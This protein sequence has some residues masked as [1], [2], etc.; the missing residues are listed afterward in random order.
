[1]KQEISKRKDGSI[2]VLHFC[3][4][5]SMTRPSFQEEC[6]INNII[7]KFNQT[8]Q[9]HHLAE[10]LPF[11][12]DVTEIKDLRTALEVARQAEENFMQMPSSLREK[13]NND[14]GLLIDFLNDGRN[15]KEALELGL[16]E[17]TEPEVQPQP[18]V[19]NPEPKKD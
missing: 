5:E 12:G 14:P 13:F 4:G 2:Q 17:R 16:I 15:Y 3:E 1:M 6:D 9:V 7:K 19:G 11:Y 18:P 10:G 8:G